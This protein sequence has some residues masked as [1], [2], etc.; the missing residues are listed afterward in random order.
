MIGLSNECVGQE[1]HDFCAAIDGD[2]R[3]KGRG[4]TLS[5]LLSLLAVYANAE[6]VLLAHAP[7]KKRA[8]RE[9]V[10]A[11]IAAKVAAEA[12]APRSRRSQAT[13]HEPSRTWKDQVVD[14]S[15]LSKLNSWRLLK[16]IKIK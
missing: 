11:A 4:K 3:G 10:I 13:A 16:L 2:V 14:A 1:F 5:S 6:K 12:T 15:A 7:P 8:E 9:D